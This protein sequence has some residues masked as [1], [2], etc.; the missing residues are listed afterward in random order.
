MNKNICIMC[1]TEFESDKAD[2]YACEDCQ[3][4]MKL[5]KKMEMID[6]ARKEM[7]KRKG[8]NRSLKPKLDMSKYS[9][10]V[11]DRVIKEIDNFSSMPEAIVAIQME[12]IGLK[13]EAQK[14]I[15]GKK[16]DFYIPEIKIILEIDGEIYHTDEDKAFLRDRQIMREVGE[17]W[18]IV[19][20]KTDEIPKYTWNLREALPFVATQ[21]NENW[22]FR[23]SRM[24][25]EFLHD[26]KD[27]EFYMKRSGE[28]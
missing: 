28:K 12:H 16:V 20:I 10:L 5:I 13:Y 27:L 15:A 6:K 8:R 25:S 4:K 7:E 1:G 11:K 22:R 24:D 23:D 9:D 26:F 3:K 21:R 2:I 18:E 19:H 14:E 17:K